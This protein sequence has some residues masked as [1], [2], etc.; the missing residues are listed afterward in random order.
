MTLSGMIFMA[1]SWSFI[2][3]LSVFTL[4]RAIRK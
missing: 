1:A 2:I 4:S 3:F